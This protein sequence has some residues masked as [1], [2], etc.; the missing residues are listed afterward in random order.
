M[1]VLPLKVRH[2]T[3]RAEILRV[4]KICFINRGLHKTS[5]TNLCQACGLSAGQVYR[6]FA[7]KEEIVRAL[8]GKI[9]KERIIKMHKNTID[10]KVIPE[11][12]ASRDVTF[13]NLECDEC[14]LFMR[15]V[16]AE[17][18][19]NSYY[20]VLLQEADGILFNDVLRKLSENFPD[21]SECDIKA[22]IEIIATLF[23]GKLCRSI[24]NQNVKEKAL[25]KAY[26]NIFFA[27]FQ[28]YSTLNKEV[29]DGII[30][31]SYNK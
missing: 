8:I 3:R 27:L 5:M 22:R 1:K 25:L 29:I 12:L 17:A 15:E 9:T 20:R 10:I 21:M 30:G 6:Y 13:C 11:I 24:M 4:A 18:A 26:Q 2:E 16:A 14:Q 28:M 23:E 19:R 31:T 7:S